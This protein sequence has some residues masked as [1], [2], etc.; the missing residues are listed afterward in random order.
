MMKRTR[1]KQWITG[2]F[3]AL[4]AMPLFSGAQ[5]III[6]KPVKAGELTLFPGMEDPNSYYYLP[7]KLRLATDASGK[8]QFSFLRYVQNI[9][10]GPDEEAREGTG[11]GIVH[12]VVE[13]S[14]TPEQIA[15]ARSALRS[16]NGD[17]VIK[18]PVIYS[19]GTM[20][21][22]SSF[23]NTAGDLTEQVVGIGR[24]PLVDGQKAAVS[25]ELT[26]KGAKI[27]W[28]SFQTPT[29][30]MSF[31]LEMELE[32]Y[33]APK[34]A[35]IEANFEKIYSHHG[36][37]LGASGN[38]GNIVFGGEIDLAFDE[39]RNDGAIKITN[40]GADED[41]EKLIETAYNKLTTMM[42][43]P[44]GG[45][46]NPLIKNIAGAVGGQKSPM[47]RA[48]DL[49]KQVKKTPHGKKTTSLWH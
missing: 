48:T 35:I 16:I 2:L 42:F 32:G 8:P 34:K 49:Y 33:R 36:F 10:S 3:F 30:D 14:V 15:E 13:L 31:S 44:I 5:Q 17:G 12:A 41:M 28:E 25:M 21:I 11:G 4:L 27:L 24:A 18:G 22:V 38:Y 1:A 29:P 37:Q 19:S 45:T 46:G 40:M 39:L 9:R 47:D 26:K 23:T 6:D 43:Q 7:D 20:T